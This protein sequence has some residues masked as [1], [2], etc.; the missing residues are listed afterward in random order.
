M[1]RKLPPNVVFH[2]DLHLMVYRPRGIFDEKEV[3]R[4]IGFL[5]NEEDRAERPFDRFTDTSKLDAVNLDF[6]FVFRVSLHRRLLYAHRPAVRSAFYIT[7]PATERII[8]IHALLT[9]QS[10]LQVKMFK[11]LAAAA[12]WLEV[13]VETLE[14]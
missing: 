2:Q 14:Y 4:I 11:G 6:Q 1:K 9:E 12:K 8:R 3:N 10:P 13:S 7:S 5:E